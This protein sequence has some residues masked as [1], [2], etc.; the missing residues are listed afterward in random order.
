M[1]TRRKLIVGN[2]KMNGRL[3]SGLNLAKEIANRA[4]ESMP[5]EFDVALCPP[6]TLLWPISEALMGSPVMLGAQDCHYA[7]HGA[8]TGDISAGMLADLG[9]RYVI[10]G[11]SERR[12]A[13]E[14][15]GALIAKKVAAAQLAGLVTIVCV[16]ETLEQ[17]AT[18][19]TE[20]AIVQQ[21]SSSLP[22]KFHSSQLVVAYEPVWAIGSGDVPE[23]DEVS[24]IHRL[25]RRSLGA[26]GE[27]VQV[28]YGGSVVPHN[29]RD[30][31]EQHEIDGVLVG[32]AS[33]NSDG[34]W[35]I[36]EKAR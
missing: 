16:G 34:F 33:L 2:W 3:T 9:C 1:A 4:I 21:L 24:S 5:L 15:T 17:R 25:I 22:E 18:G 8:Y 27:A 6:A 26:M 19:T 10:L 13:Y 29:A 36:A 12:A 20:T 14:E 35:S 11:H 28:I 7:N 30:L 23:T 32:G 31:L